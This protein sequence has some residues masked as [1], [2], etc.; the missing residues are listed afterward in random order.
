MS[1]MEF[2]VMDENSN[3]VARGNQPF[4]DRD[5]R[6]MKGRAPDRNLRREREAQKNPHE[7]GWW[8]LTRG[9]GPIVALALHAGHDL[10]PELQDCM[11]V[12]ER[13]RFHEEDPYTDL[14]TDV[15]GNR[16]VAHRSRF[17]VDLNRPRVKSV[18]LRPED[19]WGIKVWRKPP[20]L[21]DI[22]KAFAIYDAFYHAAETMC[23]ELVERHGHFLV[24]DLHSYNCRFRTDEGNGN[25]REKCP[26]VNVGTGTMN[27]RYWAP[28]VDAFIV[29]LRSYEYQGEPLEVRENFNFRGGNFA[30]WVHTK[31][32]KTGC[33]IAIEF[34]KFFMDEWSGEFN[35]ADLE[36]VHKILAYTLPALREGLA[37]MK[38]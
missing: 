3:P 2:R 32:P 12:D 15:V 38:S 22:H 4:A 25:G 6:R 28:V 27:R 16:I 10:R 36:E 20:R 18:Y 9:E 11:D 8:T 30:R 37:R 24:L 21:D 19:A 26:D 29:A 5:F 17:E 7:K 13:V 1:L 31:F 14:W 34:E 35:P 33:C 23:R